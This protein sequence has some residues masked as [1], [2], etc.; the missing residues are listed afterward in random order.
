MNEKK[1]TLNLNGVQYSTL[2]ALALIN[3]CRTIEE[4]IKKFF[5]DK[6]NL[7][8]TA[9]IIDKPFNEQKGIETIVSNPISFVRFIIENSWVV[10][11][12]DFEEIANSMRDVIDEFIENDE[13][14]SLNEY[15]EKTGFGIE[16]YDDYVMAMIESKINDYKNFYKAYCELKLFLEL[17]REE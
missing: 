8:D 4:Y 6:S 5:I 17:L 2:I 16:I 3:G 9:S 14:G 10:Q 7:E 15:Y 1:V 13:Q 12:Y 11:V